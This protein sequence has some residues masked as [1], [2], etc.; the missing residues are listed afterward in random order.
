MPRITKKERILQYAAA[1][2]WTLIGDA[3]WKELHTSLPDIADDTFRSAGLPVAQPWLGV[4][5]HSMEELESS[6]ID[7]AR[8]YEMRRDLRSWC[9]KQVIRA[10]DRARWLSRKQLSRKHQS[11][12]EMVEW[13]LVWL[14]DPSMFEAWAVG[15][16]R[17]KRNSMPDEHRVKCDVCGATGQCTVCKG[18]SNGGQCFNCAGTG[19]C[20]Q[21]QGSGRREAI[22][23]K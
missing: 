1:R 4:T 22:H 9:R 5:Q 18:T 14:G 10:K 17:A 21:C 23:V 12:A 11:K 19:N 7:L 3:E 15:V 16:K 6:L 2:G 13:M 8:I 20:P